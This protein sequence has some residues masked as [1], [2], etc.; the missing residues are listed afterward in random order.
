MYE[1]DPAILATWLD[2]EDAARAY[3]VSTRTMRR[4]LSRGELAAG[5]LTT[6]RGREWR[7]RPPGPGDARAPEP[8]HPAA[9]PGQALIPLAAIEQLL[10]PYVQQQDDLRAEIARLQAARLD[11]A[12]TIGRLEERLA[13]LEA[14]R[15]GGAPA[16]VP[17]PDVPRP[18]SGEARPRRRWPWQR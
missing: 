17:P 12:R 15:A 14:G 8:E 1:T 9:A 3:G 4:R 13:Q 10:A 2:I 6:N 5:H 7:V 16:T 11:D 18:A